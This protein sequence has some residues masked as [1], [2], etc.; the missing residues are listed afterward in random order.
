MAKKN[1]SSAGIFDG[2]EIAGIDDDFSM[3]LSEGGD[4]DKEKGSGKE[5]DK[6]DDKGKD[7]AG[8]A[9]TSFPGLD[10]STKI[11]VPETKEE[12]DLIEKKGSAGSNKSD[13]VD[14]DEKEE[15][16]DKGGEEEDAIITEDSP[17]YLHAATLLEDG[18]LPTLKPEEL[19]GKKYSEAL[20]IYLDKQKTYIEE[21]RSEYMNSLSERQK[22]FLEMIDKGIPQEQVEH[23]FTIEDAYSKV[24]DEILSDDTELQ[25]QL[26]ANNFKLKGVGDKQIEVF[27]NAS[28][29]KETL[30]EDSKAAL[31][32][33]NAYIKDQKETMIKKADE[34]QKA[35]EEN[36]KNLQKKVKD[37]IDGLK[38]VFP[39][40]EISA[41]EKTDF[42]EYMT[43]P[44]EVRN[45][46]GHKVPVS[47]INKKREEDPIAFNL[48]LIY[49][50][51]QGLF[52]KD[53]KDTKFTRKI[54][55]GAAERLSSKF[56]GD[57]GVLGQGTETSKDDKNK[58][59][60]K[61]IF[62]RF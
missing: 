49:Y 2:S 38:E 42:Y 59:P 51:Q 50:I 4:S 29:E 7:D 55:S 40:I 26:I 20:E 12:L 24:T 35:A 62:P 10:M 43:K 30:F 46:N 17:L 33:I 58:K 45:V 31:D 48:K 13:D 11:E 1:E 36:E 8:K 41:K 5:T 34:E 9:N 52:D 14:D 6:D 21:G 3:V 27:I 37:T 28:K 61:V 44:V 23:Q 57:Q 25:E 19:L 39:G 22:D 18:I 16:K 56:K 53:V 32:E 47:F 15:G 54:T 60:G